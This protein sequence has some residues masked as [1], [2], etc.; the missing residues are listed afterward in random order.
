[1]SSTTMPVSGNILN[2]AH[3]LPAQH[4]V[5]VWHDPFNFPLLPV[6]L[7]AGLWFTFAGRRA[8]RLFLFSIGGVASGTFLSHFVFRLGTLC[9]SVQSPAL[10]CSRHNAFSQTHAYTLAQ[11]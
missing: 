5:D 1:M 11:R 7:L 4:I 9:C 6:I 2:T 8:H 3:S 10:R